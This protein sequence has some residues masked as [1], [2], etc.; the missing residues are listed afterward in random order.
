M[1]PSDIA[2]EAVEAAHHAGSGIV[3]EFKKFG[4]AFFSQLLGSSPNADL[5]HNEIKDLVKGDK[6]FSEAASA[7]V[8]AR[9]K[10][11]YDEYYA[12]QKKRQEKMEEAEEQKEEEGNKLEE[13]NEQRVAKAQMGVSPEIAKT[14][15]EIKNY[16]SE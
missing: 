1:D 3:G 8:A 13:L 16:G 4:S 14:R 15:A 12:I 2:N 7:E 9:V 5:K 10:A 6:E 11:Y